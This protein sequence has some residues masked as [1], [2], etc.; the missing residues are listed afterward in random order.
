M[1]E[2]NAT[3][4]ILSSPQHEYTRML[5]GSVPSITPRHRDAPADAPLVLRTRALAKTYAAS[6]WLH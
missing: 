2:M 5:I 3:K 4:E 1:V 6:G